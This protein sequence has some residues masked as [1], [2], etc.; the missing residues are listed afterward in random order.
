MNQRASLRRISL[1]SK[2]VEM[3]SARQSAEKCEIMG[4]VDRN[5]PLAVT[6]HAANHHEATLVQLTFDFYMIEAKPEKLIG[7]KAYDSNRL[8]EEMNK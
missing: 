6:A 3:A 2:A 5:G 4:I 1:Q 8:N 7:N